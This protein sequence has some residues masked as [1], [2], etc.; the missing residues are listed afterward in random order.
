[1][2]PQGAEDVYSWA[3]CHER[4]GPTSSRVGQGPHLCSPRFA[5]K[6]VAP[7]GVLWVK[8]AARASPLHSP[9][10]GQVPEGGGHVHRCPLP[11][12]R[13]RRSGD[14]PEGGGTPGPPLRRS[15]DHLVCRLLLEKKKK[16][17]K[18]IHKKIK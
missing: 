8:T 15:R 2:L 7:R 16:T 13:V 14:R 3:S 17:N 6:E 5:G 4:V 1:M 12:N 9:R 10:S 11:R 18:T